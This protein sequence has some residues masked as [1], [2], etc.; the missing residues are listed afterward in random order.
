MNKRALA[1]YIIVGL[2]LALLF[3]MQ[4]G[5]SDKAEL[6]LKLSS[7]S[8]GVTEWLP[9]L[10][11]ADGE[12]QILLIAANDGSGIENQVEIYTDDAG[13]ILESVVSSNDYS[14]AYRIQLTN[15]S[16][17]V[18]IRTIADEEG[19]KV[20]LTGMV[21]EPANEGGILYTDT[22]WFVVFFLLLYA[23]LGLYLFNSRLDQQ[24]ALPVLI[25]FAAVVAASTPL[26][27]PYLTVGHDIRFHL[28]RI[29]SIKDALLSGQFPVRLHP[30][31]NHGYGYGTSALYPE[32]FLYI[33]AVFRI[34]GMSIPMA[35]QVFCFLIN[36]TTAFTVYYSMNLITRSR[37][38]SL[39][40]SLI[41][42]LSLY[43]L[44]C[45]YERAALGEVLGLCFIP[46]VIAGL[47]HVL[48]GEQKRWPVLMI[49][50]TLV[51]QTHMIST[52]LTAALGVVLGLVYLPR[53]LKDRRWLSLAKALGGTV[54]LSMWFLIPM[55]DFYR[56]DLRMH[57]VTSFT[58]YQNAVYVPQLL[59]GLGRGTGLSY[60]LA[61]GQLGEMT[62]TVGL[63]VWLCV[64][65]CG[66]VYLVDRKQKKGFG[67]VLF[68][69]GLF[70]LLATTTWF[71]W[72]QLE[73]FAVVEKIVTVLQFP[74]RLLGYSSLLFVMAAGLLLAENE[75]RIKGKEKY[76]VLA[77]AAGIGL[78][79]VTQ[80]NMTM[81]N[82]EIFLQ[83]T[84]AIPT[85]GA[86]G[87]TE[88]YLLDGHDF[89]R[90][91]PGNYVLSDD[92]I[93]LSGQ[94]KYG[95]NV[96]FSYS[97]AKEG[98]WVEVPL[99]WYPGY[100]AVDETGEVMTLAR[101]DGNYLRVYLEGE[102]GEVHITYGSRKIYRA[103]EACTLASLAAMA[104]YAIINGKNKR[105]RETEKNA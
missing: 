6:S 68:L 17:I 2:L 27:K 71:P 49:G 31:F 55:F 5:S 84:E 4:I 64:L 74:W 89:S 18:Y 92:E 86:N 85:G 94:Y 70:S 30:T 104:G 75:E 16:N 59:E 99:L 102:T 56:L 61:G 7:E 24:K 22:I 34:L 69:G 29:E 19:A 50:C 43:R 95:T 23:L 28:Y 54:L 91:I 1:G 13:T 8:D 47:Y 72:E 48:L 12:Y 51:F 39:A 82:Q 62:M 66:G 105:R 88:E 77:I 26:L 65:I 14:T 38:A 63:L 41:Y 103:G 40:T 67:F 35:Y 58:F 100:R 33:P 42:T 98:D 81:D 57:S 11:L 36:L 15:P 20:S 90:C 80:Y 32:L 78:Y 3:A 10:S 101:G 25:L 83:K 60:D 45:L 37:Y 96:S 52:V 87:E 53:L 97:E 79:G 9:G 21:V 44:V 46:L 93:E 76:A 73:H